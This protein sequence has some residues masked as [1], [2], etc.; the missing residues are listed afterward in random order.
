M[1][2]EIN[3]TLRWLAIAIGSILLFSELTKDKPEKKKKRSKHGYQAEEF[4][5]I[6]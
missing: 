4:D 1:L 3:R 6:W 2:R 5:D